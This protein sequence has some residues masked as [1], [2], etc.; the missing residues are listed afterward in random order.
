[1]WMTEVLNG[2][3]TIPDYFHHQRLLPFSKSSSPEVEIDKIR[4]IVI[5]NHLTNIFENTILNKIN[6]MGSHLLKVP[7]Y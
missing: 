7:E 3:R 1:M 5:N 2:H 4:G 6:Q